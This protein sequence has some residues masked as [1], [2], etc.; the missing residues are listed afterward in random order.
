MYLI[1]SLPWTFKKNIYII[2]FIFLR[3]FVWLP[4]SRKY[5]KF[6]VKQ[7]WRVEMIK[8]RSKWVMVTGGILD[9]KG[10]FILYVKT[11]TLRWRQLNV[12]EMD[13][14]KSALFSHFFFLFT[15]HFWFFVFPFELGLFFLYNVL[16][17]KKQ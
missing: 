9:S 10:F 14:F 2:D 7:F 12:S 13:F 17:K 1:F 6:S 15:Y 8:E 16:F 11:I 3:T 5:A 4:L